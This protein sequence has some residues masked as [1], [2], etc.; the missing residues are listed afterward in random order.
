MQKPGTIGI[1]YG[2][3]FVEHPPQHL[4]NALAAQADP[5]DAFHDIQ[6]AEAAGELLFQLF[7]RGNVVRD[8]QHTDQ[9][10]FCILHRRLD[11]F[12]QGAM[13]VVGEDDPFLIDAGLACRHRDAVV[14]A[15]K[16]RQLLAHKIVIGFADDIRFCCAEKTLEHRVATQIDAFRILQPNQVGYGSHQSTQTGFI[17]FQRHRHPLALGDVAYGRGK[18]PFGAGLPLRQRKLQGKLPAILAQ[19]GKLDGLAYE[20]QLSA[21]CHSR[22]TFAISFTESLRHQTGQGLPDDFA[23]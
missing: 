9:I 22:P 18:E 1:E 19:P 3:Y 12:Q 7:A 2:Q 23:F 16:I 4:F 21:R 14:L 10:S 20:A 17:L 15:E 11:G 6:M 5:R 8:A 13:A